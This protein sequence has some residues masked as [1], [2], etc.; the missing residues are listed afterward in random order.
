MSKLEVEG[1]GLEEV[2]LGEQVFDGHEFVVGVDLGLDSYQG[3]A[4]ELVDLEH[5]S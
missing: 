2:V 3:V 4:A 5:L 1:T